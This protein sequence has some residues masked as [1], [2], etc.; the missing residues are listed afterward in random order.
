MDSV[1]MNKIL[2]QLAPLELIRPV[3]NHQNKPPV[4][5][6][7][8][9]VVDA[10]NKDLYVNGFQEE[11]QYQS[12]TPENLQ[13]MF[14]Q[15]IERLDSARMINVTHLALWKPSS[16]KLGNPVEF[17]LDDSYDTFWQSDGG[18]PH[19]LDILFSKR[20]D[21]CVM[22]LFFSMIADESY[23]PSLVKVY[24]G[25]SSSDVTFYKMLE[26]RN[27]NGWVALRFPDN[28]DGDQLL[29]CQFIRLLFPVN[30]ENGKDTHLRGIRLYVPSSEPHRETHEWAQTL[31]ETS[32]MFHDTILR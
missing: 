29:K 25:H 20:M 23:A 15:G 18:Q 10:A 3:K 30:H 4:L 27:V 6:I 21:I 8:D 13:H 11:A 12:L 32:N 28:R 5:V 16:F 2:N 22:A 26:V 24:V 17:A 31:P 19:Q 1:G 9:R 7:D 14:H